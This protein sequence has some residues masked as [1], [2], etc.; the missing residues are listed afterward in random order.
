[1]NLCAR[2]TATGPA[3]EIRL[4]KAAF[5]ELASQNRSR[6]QTLAPAELKGIPRP[7]EMMLYRWHTQGPRPTWVC[8][9]ESGERVPLP[10]K[11]VITFGRLKEHHGVQANDIVLLP[12]KVEH[13]QRISRWHFEVRQ[14][15]DGLCVSGLSDQTTEVDGKLVSRGQSAPLGVGTVVRVAGVMTLIFQADESQQ[16]AAEADRHTQMWNVQNLGFDES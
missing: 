16:P 3:G 10:D 14:T 12:A 9:Q 8:I 2:V 6:C 13:Q 1:V 15:I 4:T 11:P 5:L 7:V